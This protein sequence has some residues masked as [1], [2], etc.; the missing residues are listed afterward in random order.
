MEVRIWIGVDDQN[1]MSPCSR[2]PGH[3][4]RQCGFADSTF[5]AQC[6]FHNEVLTA[7]PNGRN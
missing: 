1:R 4:G 2:L 3:Q 6:D 5:A 7:Q